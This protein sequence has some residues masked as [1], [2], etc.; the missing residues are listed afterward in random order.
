MLLSHRGIDCDIA[1]NGLEAITMYKA[2]FQDRGARRN[3]V[4]VIFIDLAMPIMN[5]LDASTIIR[6]MDFT[7]LIIGLTGNVLDGE[8]IRFQSAGADAVICKPL[9][10][11]V[12]ARILRLNSYA[13]ECSLPS[14]QIKS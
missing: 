14:S 6:S 1:C 12:L 10:E 13:E 11:R 9:L 2:C 3:T 8:H 7:G 4:Y 5:G